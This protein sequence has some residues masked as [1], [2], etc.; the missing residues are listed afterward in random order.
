MDNRFSYMEST[1]RVRCGLEVDFY[2]VLSGVPQDSVL[3][4]LLFLVY[5]NDCVDDL[6]CSAIMFADDIKL[7]TAIRSD[8]DRFALQDILNRLNSWSARW[9]LNFN[10]DKSVVLRLRTK[11]TSN[12]D[13][14][15]QYVLGGQ[16][17][18]NVVEQKDLGILM[19]STLKPSSQCQSSAKSAIRVV[20]LDVCPVGGQQILGRPVRPGSQGMGDPRDRANFPIPYDRLSRWIYGICVV[21]FDVDVGQTLELL[22]PPNV[23]LTESEKFTVCYL[24]FPDSHSACAGNTQHHFRFS[25]TS[26]NPLLLKHQSLYQNYLQTLVPI[27]GACFGYAYFRQEKDPSF[28]RNYSQKSIVLLSPLPFDMLFY[29]VSA[30]I[31]RNYFE[32]GEKGL[33]EACREMERWPAPEAGKHLS[34]PLLGPFFTLKIPV[35]VGT[36]DAPGSPASSTVVSQPPSGQS[37]A[38]SDWPKEDT[39]SCDSESVLSF[40]EIKNSLSAEE[41]SASFL[42]VLRSSA[43]VPQL[44]A[45]ADADVEASYDIVPDTAEIIQQQQEIQ[46]SLETRNFLQSFACVL[47]HLQRIWELVLTAQP[48]LVMGSTPGQTSQTVQSLVSC[49]SPLAFSADYRPFFT[50]HDAELKDVSRAS[51]VSIV[52]LGVTNPFFSKTLQHWPNVIR[53]GTPLHIDRKKRVHQ[54]KT[55]MLLEELKPGLYSRYKPFLRRC[56]GFTKQLKKTLANGTPEVRVSRMIQRFFHDLTMSFLIPIEHYLSGLLP[57][58]R[59]ISPYKDVPESG[60]FNMEEFFRTLETLGPQLTCELKG[61]WVG[62]YRTFFSGPHFV[63]WLTRRESEIRAKLQSLHLSA[64]ACA[65]FTL[66]LQDRSEIEIVDMIIQ[67][68]QR[69]EAISQLR[70]GACDITARSLRKQIGVLLQALP[71]DLRNV[72]ENSASGTGATM[73]T[74]ALSELS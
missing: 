40:S 2:P 34:L 8:A 27:P 5:I 42:P 54:P 12:E 68:N 62:L 15:F 37:S 19:T 49:I 28:K 55:G 4:P 48:L 41:S 65:D 25:S 35:V 20:P 21:N 30:I 29:E 31:A 50:I 7:W 18:S 46:V 33:Q 39:E 63:A 38:R 71:E 43:S 58:Q 74:V 1:N 52:I 22:Y 44:D 45:N 6:G 60:R 47:P 36:A 32:K 10:V 3:G 9:P 51:P 14:S 59:D 66:W 16:P 61:D 67:L 64:I 72:V 11:K 17:L 57:F 69:I 53:L 26:V 23:T 70:P 13:D 73:S 56:S 24:A